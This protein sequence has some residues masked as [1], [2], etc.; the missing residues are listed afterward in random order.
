MFQKFH[1]SLEKFKPRIFRILWKFPEKFE[2][3]QDSFQENPL[4]TIEQPIR[5][6]Y[7]QFQKITQIPTFLENSKNLPETILG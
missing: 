3:V 4:L 7:F 2:N 5:M 6:F 1:N